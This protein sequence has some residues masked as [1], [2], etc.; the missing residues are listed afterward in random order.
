MSPCHSAH[1]ADSLIM[2]VHAIRQTRQT[3]SSWESMPFGKPGRRTHHVSPCHSANRA[4]SGSLSNHHDPG[5]NCGMPST[6]PPSYSTRTSVTGS[7]LASL[8]GRSRH[9]DQTLEALLPHPHPWLLAL[10]CS[11][12]QLMTAPLLWTSHWPLCEAEAA[13]PVMM[14]KPTPHLSLPTLQ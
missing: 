9:T 1:Q 2:V 5:M 3:H 14:R 4:D 13:E 12:L 7:A 11:E 10:A 6:A 8:R